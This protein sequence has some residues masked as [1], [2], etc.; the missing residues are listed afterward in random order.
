[1]H[2]LKSL[3]AL[4]GRQ[5]RQTEHA[6]LIRSRN[7]YPAVGP[8]EARQFSHKIAV[9]LEV[10]DNFDGR[11]DVPALIGTPPARESLRTQPHLLRCIERM[12]RIVT[13][14]QVL[15]RPFANADGFHHDFPGPSEETLCASKQIE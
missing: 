2:V 1:V 5:C 14:A 3:K 8:S 9:I 6:E 7:D 11:S 12:D 10:F 15:A 13:D 4:L